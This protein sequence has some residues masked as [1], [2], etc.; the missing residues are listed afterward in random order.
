MGV[1]YAARSA[2]VDAAAGNLSL[3]L[4]Q[5]DD[6]RERLKLVSRHYD[7]AGDREV[8]QDIPVASI[9]FEAE[10]FRAN[11]GTLAAAFDVA[12]ATD[13]PAAIELTLWATSTA[14][15]IPGTYVW[16]LRGADAQAGT[17]MTYLQGTLEIRPRPQ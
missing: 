6:F 10:V 13:D 5:G 4:T 9:V 2:A 14:A 15:M 8:R 7:A 11:D 3:R 1:P 16:W 12:D 17:A